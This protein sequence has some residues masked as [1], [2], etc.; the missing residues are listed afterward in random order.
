M[1]ARIVKK[2]LEN[3][4]QR[5]WE[6]DW[7]RGEVAFR[8]LDPFFDAM[9][10]ADKA[11][12]VFNDDVF[13]VACERDDEHPLTPEWAHLS[14]VNLNKTVQFSCDRKPY[15]AEFWA[16][17]RAAPDADADAEPEIEFRVSLPTRHIMSIPTSLG[18]REAQ[19]SK[20]K[21]EYYVWGKRSVV[22]NP[23]LKALH[24]QVP[25]LAN[26]AQF[27]FLTVPPPQHVELQLSQ[28]G[29]YLELRFQQDHARVVVTFTPFRC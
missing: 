28:S 20:T 11:G 9:I 10:K 2:G 7:R 1:W 3:P 13:A 27:F 14:G 17:A 5:R 29:K 6:P 4:D 19:D 22:C 26:W 8:L 25:A 16:R 24:S 23:T 15:A 12:S 21:A 18:P